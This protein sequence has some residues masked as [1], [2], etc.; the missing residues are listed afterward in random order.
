VKPLVSAIMLTYN[1]PFFV[2]RSVELFLNQTWPNKELIILDDGPGL[3][4]ADISWPDNVRHIRCDRAW[5]TKKRAQGYLAAKGELVCCWDDDDYFGP[6]R[7][8]VQAE[9]LIDGKVDACG[10]ALDY[11]V[12]VPSL[13]FYR[14]RQAPGR[15]I[16][17]HDGTMMTW[18]WMLLTLPAAIREEASQFTMLQMMAGKGF[19]L[20]ELPNLG[21]FIYVRHAHSVWNEELDKHASPSGPPSWTPFKQMEFWGDPR[22]A[23]QGQ[24]GGYVK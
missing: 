19:R 23:F 18:R 21:H 10:F 24:G 15:Q 17:F 8:Q 14:W 13:R 9:A 5:I 12:R 3:G 7:L 16:K 2:E 11:V 4:G 6:R 20:G 1:R 22:L